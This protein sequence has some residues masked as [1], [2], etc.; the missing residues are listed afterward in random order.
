MHTVTLCEEG[1]GLSS[2]DI[3]SITAY[4]KAR[5]KSDYSDI[6]SAIGRACQGIGQNAVFTV[7]VSGLWNAMDF[8]QSHASKAIGIEILWYS[9]TNNT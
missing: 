4:I 3:V 6:E 8:E 7:P 1:S 5:N 9:N 2:T